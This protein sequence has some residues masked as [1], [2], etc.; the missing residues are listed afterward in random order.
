MNRNAIILEVPTD[1]PYIALTFDDGPDPLYTT[2]ILDILAASGASAS[3]YMVGSMIEKH[4]EI[5]SKVH[6]AGHEIGNHTYTH[7][8]PTQIGHERLQDEL[9][10]TDRLI[11]GITGRSPATFRP[12][13]LDFDEGVAAVAES[14]GYRSIGAVNLET[15]DWAEPGVEHIVRETRA[16]CRNGSILVLHDGMGD[17]SQTVEAVRI[18]VPE[19]TQAGYRF[20]TVSELLSK[21]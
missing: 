16:R 14:F 6:E 15:R 7:P 21:G 1:R 17:R 13:Y 18:L 8:Y 11:R 4:P 2:Q 5:A 19:L 20:V 10:M 12:P 3:F 9:R